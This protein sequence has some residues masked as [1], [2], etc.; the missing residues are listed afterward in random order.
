MTISWDVSRKILE[1]YI[2]TVESSACK[3]FL[4]NF[5]F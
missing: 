3:V 4:K 5:G 1:Q 2:E